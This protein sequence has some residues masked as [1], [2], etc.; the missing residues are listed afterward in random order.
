MFLK[1][2]FPRR[3]RW[4]LQNQESTK[5][6]K[7]L[8]PSS[9][10]RRMSWLWSFLTVVLL[11]FHLPIC[12]SSLTADLFENWCKEYGKAYPSQQEKQHRLK[13]FE[14]NYDYV[15]K[16]NRLSNSTYTLSLNAFA[17]LTH[18]E[19]KARYLGLSASANNLIRLNRGSSSLKASNA[20]GKVHI[21]SSLDWRKKGVVTNVKDQGN[22]G[23]WLFLL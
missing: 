2:H 17:D 16:Y 15:T 10:T 4:Y 8:Y 11:V 23:M 6:L 22:C 18:H 13:I 12:R 5:T 19:F 21:P 1:L 9:Q 20:V 3:I 7:S 14:D